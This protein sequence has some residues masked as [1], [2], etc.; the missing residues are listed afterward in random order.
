METSVICTTNRTVPIGILQIFSE[1]LIFCNC[2]HELIDSWKN[3]AWKVSKYGVFSGTYFLRKSPYSVRIQE[4]TDKKKLRIWTLFTQCNIWEI[5][6]IFA[7]FAWGC[8]A[9]KLV[10]CLHENVEIVEIY[11]NL[12]TWSASDEIIYYERLV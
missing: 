4:H 8:R 11:Q 3:T 7:N 1:F 12:D 10:Y 5:R 2:F 9:R 6:K